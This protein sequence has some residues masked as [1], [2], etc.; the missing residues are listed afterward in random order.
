MNGCAITRPMRVDDVELTV[1]PISLADVDRLYDLF[2]R[3]SPESVHSRFFSPIRRPPKIFM[4]RLA[5]VDHVRRDALIAMDGDQ[6]VAVA[7]YDAPAGAVDAEIALTV[8]DDW[9]HRGIGLRLASRLACL[10]ASRGYENFTATML[11]DNRAALGLVRKL[12]PNATVRFAGGGY[13][14]TMPLPKAS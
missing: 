3:L 1:R 10:A 4:L 2:G 11:S 12:S 7:R 9:Q 14:A 13:E 8:A 5:A 6:I